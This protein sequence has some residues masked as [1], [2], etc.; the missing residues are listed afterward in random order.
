MG[1]LL[2]VY[3]KLTLSSRNEKT[4]FWH[5][6]C[7]SFS[8]S[9][10]LCHTWLVTLQ[11]FL[12]S[13]L[14]SLYSK[15]HL[16]NTSTSEQSMRKRGYLYMS[17]E[18]LEAPCRRSSA[19]NLQPR[20]CWLTMFGLRLLQLNSQSK[21]VVNVMWIKAQERVV[22]NKWLLFFNRPSVIQR[23]VELYGDKR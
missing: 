2:L 4:L 11:M 16:F 22:Q 6:R 10:P 20:G 14:P 12:T 5:L 18:R 15:S 17:W 8:P 23:L 7:F 1:C 19:S 9:P 13:L 3:G 21:E